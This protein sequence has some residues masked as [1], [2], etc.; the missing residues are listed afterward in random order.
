VSLALPL[1]LN[2]REVELELQPVPAGS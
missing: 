2:L 1:F